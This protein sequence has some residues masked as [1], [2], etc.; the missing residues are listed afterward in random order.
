MVKLVPKTKNQ[1]SKETK[2]NKESLNNN[3]K[4]ASMAKKEPDT[5]QQSPAPQS[6]PQAASGTDIAATTQAEAKA[7]IKQPQFDLSALQ[8]ECE[9]KKADL[10]ALRSSVSPENVVI[11]DNLLAL[12]NPERLG[13]SDETEVRWTVPRLNICQSTTQAVERPQ[14]ARPGDLYTKN[15]ELLP[16]P[17]EIV[18]LYTYESN[19]NFA[20]GDM[21]RP[22]CSAPDAKLGSPFGFC[23]RCPH[24]P[25]GKQ[26]GGNGDQVQTDCNNQINFIITNA[27]MDKLYEVSFAKTSHSAGRA[28]RSMAG[29]GKY[30]WEKV[31]SLNTEQKKGD[32]G[33]Y[34]VFTV[35]PATTVVDG[36]PATKTIEGDREKIARALYYY[37]AANRNLAKASHYARV[38]SGRTAAAQIEERDS[39][40]DQELVQGLG[41]SAD[42]I[43]PTDEPVK[44]NAVRGNAAP[45]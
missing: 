27:N 13:I 23:E 17:Y 25:F 26:N 14:D 2:N 6:A 32:Q 3:G 44:G 42:G 1:R 12:A 40:V 4:G 9:T 5:K 39:G 33:A 34:F 15:G 22:V 21:K 10:A 19:V 11:V 31:F 24:L 29:R 16:K 18:V 35:A 7:L 8:R 36:K 20:P 30:A 41:G 37:V 28:L 38:A 43:E 45:M